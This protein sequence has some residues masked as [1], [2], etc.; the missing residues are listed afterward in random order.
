MYT[1]GKIDRAI[2]FVSIGAS[3]IVYGVSYA[4]RK[5]HKKTRVERGLNK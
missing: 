1:A 3:S 2:A 4:L 5:R